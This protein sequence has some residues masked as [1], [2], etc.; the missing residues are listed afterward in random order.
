M[1]RIGEETGELGYILKNL[2]MFDKRQV[3]NAFDSI[4]VH[5]EPAMIVV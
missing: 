2:A 3:E 5:I 1:V 4:I